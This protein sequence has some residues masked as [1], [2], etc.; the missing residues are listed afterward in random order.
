MSVGV[1]A[2]TTEVGA[3]GV[4]VGVTEAPA[5][6]EEMGVNKSSEEA[7]KTATE[8]LQASSSG[9]INVKTIIGT[10]HLHGFIAFSLFAVGIS[11]RE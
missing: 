4:N 7:G 9:A 1:S 11:T 10:Y 5:G 8:K 2:G 6:G 3:S